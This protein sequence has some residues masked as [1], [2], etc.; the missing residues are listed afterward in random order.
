M[1]CVF[2]YEREGFDAAEY[3]QKNLLSPVPYLDWEIG[4]CIAASEADFYDFEAQKEDAVAFLEGN[5]LELERLMSQGEAWAKLD[6]GIADL[7][8]QGEVACQ[9]DYLPAE[10]MRLAGNLGIDIEITR[11]PIQEE[12]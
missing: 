7:I 6:F 5:R 9:S 8:S 10:L 2:R 11:Y 3:L 12:E 1:S 4:F